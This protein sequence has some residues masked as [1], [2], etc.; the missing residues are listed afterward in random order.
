[1]KEEVGKR[2]RQI[3]EDMGI[4]KEKFT[5]LLGFF[6]HYLGIVEHGKCDLSI[7]KLKILCDLSNLSAVS[8]TTK[9][10]IVF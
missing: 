2:I 8:L 5:K 4:T 3:R 1:M 9:M 6:G 7:E 10:Q